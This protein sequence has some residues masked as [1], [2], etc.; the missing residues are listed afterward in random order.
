M[1][2]SPEDMK[3]FS[4]IRQLTSNVSTTLVTTMALFMDIEGIYD[5]V[6]FQ[7]VRDTT[8]KHDID[9]PLVK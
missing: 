3:S 2:P 8:R 5:C 4:G 7:E 6:P 1:L 9:D